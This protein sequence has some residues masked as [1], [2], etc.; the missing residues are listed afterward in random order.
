MASV[1]SA[2]QDVKIVT[3]IYQVLHYSTLKTITQELG[4]MI[5][6]HFLFAQ[7]KPPFACC[8]VLT[9]STRLPVISRKCQ[10]KLYISVN[11]LCTFVCW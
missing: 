6:P 4:I 2:H 10:G 5:C 9:D 11:C 1:K 3:P 7:H 8:S